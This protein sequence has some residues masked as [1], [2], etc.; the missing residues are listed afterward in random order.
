MIE[1]VCV[2]VCVCM[3]VCPSILYFNAFKYHSKVSKYSTGESPLRRLESESLKEEQVMN[4]NGRYVMKEG[5][6][7][8]E[9]SA[10]REGRRERMDV[11]KEKGEGVDRGERR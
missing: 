1:F 2:C 8:K 7:R 10:K 11:S 4:G 6:G 9:N 5:S 3:C